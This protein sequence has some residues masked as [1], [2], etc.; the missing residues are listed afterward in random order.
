MKK[1]VAIIGA[2][3]VGASTAQLL[4]Y[5][6]VADVV[7]YDVVE[8]MPQGKALDL[9]EACPLYR[10][11]VSITGTNHMADIQG[12]D[13]VVITAGIA[14]KPGMSRDDLL[15]TNANILRGVSTEVARYCPNSVVI[16]VTNPMDV[17]AQLTWQTSALP[18]ERV[19]GMGGILDSARFRTFVAWQLNVSPEAVEAL[20]LG[21]HGDQMVPMP[22]FTTVKGVSITH[23]LSEDVIKGLV[24]RTRNGGAEVVSLLKSGSAYYAPA[25][26][27]VQMVRAI[28]F[29]EKQVLPVACLLSGQYG[30]DG[31]FAGVPAVLG[32]DGVERIIEFDL[33]Q[34]EKADF[35]RS[36]DAVR[37]LLQ[38]LGLK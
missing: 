10:S 1:K 36:V 5:E 38:K 33:N 21:G 20:T 3:H 26:S 17:M 19:M 14:R 35:Q 13:I 18:K 31:V 7:L 30:V 37:G 34:Q 8:G 22:R 27:T 2:G 11:C 23:L 4:A 16:V 32:K 29:D 15:T 25:A 24:E 6:A 12:S 9:S 28:L